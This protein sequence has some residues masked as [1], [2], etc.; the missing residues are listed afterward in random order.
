VSK[1]AKR[2]SD[3]AFSTAGGSAA[4]TNRSAQGSDGDAALRDPRLAHFEH[5]VNAV[6]PQLSLLIRIRAKFLEVPGLRLTP[7]Q[8]EPICGVERALGQRILDALVEMKFLYV[9]SDG[10]YARVIEQECPRW[11]CC[12]G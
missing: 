8:T 2:T 1:S 10:A 7:D 5:R 12:E 6:V 4:M 11:H 3:D 9:M